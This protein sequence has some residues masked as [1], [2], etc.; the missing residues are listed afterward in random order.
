M[1]RRAWISWTGRLALLFTA[2]MAPALTFG[3]R[4]AATGN[5][6][7]AIDGFWPGFIITIVLLVGFA[8]TFRTTPTGRLAYL[9]LGTVTV[10]LAWMAVLGLANI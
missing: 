5:A 2:F 6:E 3:V 10:V 7:Q 8:L 4:S 9:G 1:A